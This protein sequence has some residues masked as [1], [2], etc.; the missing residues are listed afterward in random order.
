[1]GQRQRQRLLLLVAD[2]AHP[3]RDVSAASVAVLGRRAGVAT[4]VYYSAPPEGMQADGGE[5]HASHGIGGLF[6]RHGSAPIGGRHQQALARA[7]AEFDV[8]VFRLGTPFAFQPLFCFGASQLVQADD[9]VDVVTEASS[10]LGLSLSEAVA[11]QTRHLPGRLE[12]GIAQYIASEAGFRG[13]IEVPVELEEVS[14]KRLVA[15]GLSSIQ[16]VAREGTDLDRWAEAGVQ[17]GW[18]DHIGDD[19]SYDDVTF[20]L[21][22]RWQDQATGYDLCE[23]VL[24]SYWLPYALRHDRVQVCAETMLS[25]TTRLAPLAAAKEPRVVF[26]RYA[27]GVLS[28]ARDDRDLFPLF[29]KSIS[30]EV[31][32]P[33]RPLLHHLPDFARPLPKPDVGA[34]DAEPSD[35]ELRDLADRGA[36]LVSLV[37]HSGELSHDDGI[38]NVIDAAV[39]T[40]VPIGVPVHVQRYEFEP[41]AVEPMSV[42]RHERGALGLAEPVLHSSGWG[43]VAESLADPGRIG[44][45]MRRA[46]Q[47]IEELAGPRAVPRGVYCYLDSTPSDWSRPN[48]D[49]WRAARDAGFE[50]VL[51]SVAPGANRLLYRD[52][53]FV[54]LNMTS[55][56]FYPASP[57]LRVNGIEQMR[58]SERSFTQDGQPGWQ[59]AVIDLPIFASQS[60]LLMGTSLPEMHAP[61]LYA[62]DH[63]GRFFDYLLRHGETHKLVAGTPHTL[64]RYARLLDDDG[65]LGHHS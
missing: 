20:R 53:D 57:F 15:A 22:Q 26:G 32:E 14:I 13:A 63:L 60:Y 50:Y 1:M 41:E 23:P 58:Q 46:R 34:F 51:S 47:R 42:P 21:A 38:L 17:V 37:F 61:D 25:A 45:D 44:A 2:F 24:A 33:G 27:G 4:D 8:V 59:V 16:V 56:N 40:G 43:I 29:E 10:L 62:G 64:A 31:V 36:H 35:D 55:N 52:G 39:L 9:V 12:H 65:R 28:A 30:F 54:V 11:V 6:S 5:R 19:D 7:L 49:L 3:H 18:A 48:E